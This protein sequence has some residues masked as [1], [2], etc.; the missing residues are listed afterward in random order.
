[1]SR[2]EQFMQA[3]DK[4]ADEIFRH[5]YYRVFDKQKAEDLVQETF[6]RTWEYFGRGE[7]IDNFRAFLYRVATNLIIDEARKNRPTES[8]EELEDEGFEPSLDEMGKIQAEI[9]SEAF[10][11]VLRELDEQHREVLT[12][13][14]VDELMPR[15]IAAILGERENTIS[16]R[17]YRGIRRLKELLE[18]RQYE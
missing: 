6:M 18:K 9:D 2:D 3:Y 13:R 17:I 15:E 10:L 14:Y 5:C 16:V 8:L 12:M 1:M 4:H 11:Q 7:K